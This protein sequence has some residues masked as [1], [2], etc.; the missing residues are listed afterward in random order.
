MFFRASACL[1]VTIAGMLLSAGPATAR[2]AYFG[3]G[4]CPM[5]ETDRHSLASAIKR[6]SYNL[7]NPNHTEDKAS[8][9]YALAQLYHIDRQYDLAIK[10][11]TG[12]IGW[13]HE[14]PEPFWA[15]GDAY[16]ALGKT[17]L[18]KADYD[19]AAKLGAARPKA[20]SDLCWAR[21]LR[22]GPFDLAMTDCNRALGARPDDDT[23]LFARCIVHY[24]L[25]EA[26][27][28]IADCDAAL[29]IDPKLAGALYVRGLAKGHSGD[30]GAAAADLAAAK[31]FSPEIAED[32]AVFGITP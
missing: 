17:D 31:V 12:A 3:F 20:A 4:L 14:A 30:A 19:M 25:G 32:Y 24:R 26:G 11:Y 16:A 18:A 8:S 15:R 9:Y 21:A 1:A 22:G 6:C 5:L 23:A 10:N 29:K 13:W 27:A 7:I 2:H 28:A